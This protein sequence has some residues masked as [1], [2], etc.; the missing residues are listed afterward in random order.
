[1][2]R[3]TAKPN[4]FSPIATYEQIEKDIR[5]RISSGDWA[6]GS[7]IPSRR[8][9]AKRYNVD[10]R[11]L[12]RAVA[13]LL[14][15]GTLR[16]EGTRGTSVVRG[17]RADMRS[18]NAEV[19]SRI[20]P[21]S[22]PD[23]GRAVVTAYDRPYFPTHATATVGLVG[24]SQSPSGDLRQFAHFSVM[25]ILQSLERTLAKTGS[26][27][28]FFERFRTD[29]PVVPIGEAISALLK[30][31]VDGLVVIDLHN[32]PEVAAVVTALSPVLPIPL[33]YVSGGV[34]IHQCLH[35]YY[36]NQSGGYV[37]AQHLL[38]QGADRLLF[39]TSF[40]AEWADFRYAGAQEAVR[41]AGLPLE[42]LSRYPPE[43]RDLKEDHEESDG[44]TVQSALKNGLIAAPGTD[45][46]GPYTGVIAANDFAA[47]DFIQAAAEVGLKPGVD[48]AILG[49]DDAPP[50]RA[51]GLTT[52]R[53][54]LEA[55]GEEAALLLQ[56]A[57]SDRTLDMEVRLRMHLVPRASTRVRTQTA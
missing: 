52:L 42:T 4:P 36:E 48:F 13:A 15:D 33:V 7:L 21:A 37:A 28:I 44:E 16:A 2:P 46:T 22:L 20:G 12:Q 51:M 54:P 8:E 23:M 9:L 24:I 39:F 55:M 43:P 41:H 30:D 31:R 50:S 35:V 14:D 18:G 3:N 5:A 53:R 32:D 10:L 40:R 47:Y 26:T 1:M 19:G 45:G 29:Q 38:H 49:F 6:V 57:L 17:V 56:R 11:T 34:V 25:P 27:T